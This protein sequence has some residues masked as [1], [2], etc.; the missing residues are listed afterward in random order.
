[1]AT[2]PIRRRLQRG[3]FRG[4]SVT[5]DA[6]MLTRRDS[7]RTLPGAS[8]RRGDVSGSTRCSARPTYK[9]R[10]FYVFLA[11]NY[12]FA[13]V[14]WTMLVFFAW[15]IWISL[16]IMVMIDNFRRR[17]H[18]GLSKAGWTLL[19]I[20]LPLIGVLTYMIARPREADALLT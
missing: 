4:S 12:P 9:R 20:F 1:M 11:S 5:A 3:R 6:A 18:S 14:M 2:A 10:W 7:R 13:D 17:D 16:V 8:S 19:V 15:V